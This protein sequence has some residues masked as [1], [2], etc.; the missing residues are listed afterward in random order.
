[1]RWPHESLLGER[2]ADAVAPAGVTAPTGGGTVTGGGVGC[3]P[4]GVGSALDDPSLDGVATLDGGVPIGVP[5]VLEV[6]TAPGGA[7]V[8]G[9]VMIAIVP[10]GIT[11]GGAPALVEV[12]QMLDSVAVGEVTE[13]PSRRSS[14]TAPTP[15]ASPMMSASPTHSGVRLGGRC[16]PVGPADPPHSTQYSSLGCVGAPHH[17]HRI[18]GIVRPPLACP[19]VDL[20]QLQRVIADTYGERDR[21]RGVPSTVAWLAEELGELAQAV[22]KG[23]RDQQLHEFGDVLAWVASLAN[24]MGIDLD[25]AL[26]RY[27]SGCPRCASMPCACPEVRVSGR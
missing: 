14:S 4:T 27:A 23:T 11:L 17:W 2:V 1:M 10:P 18:G 21:E 5:I 20:A 22:R 7:V 3:G 8:G 12:S 6:T 24:Q 16:M 13:P 19:C 25:D 15:I 26:Q 9:D